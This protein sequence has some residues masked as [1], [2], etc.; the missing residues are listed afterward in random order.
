M[1]QNQVK[2]LDEK[3]CATCGAIIKLNAEICPKCGVR[4]MAAAQEVSQ[5]G[6]DGFL[7]FVTFLFPI[8]GLIL[9]LLWIDT[10]PKAAKEVGK[11]AIISVVLMVVVAIAVVAILI[12]IGLSGSH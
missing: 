10:K 5:E 8:I 9:Y 6:A 1:E 11:V 2:S 12:A 4:Q 7:K 3:F